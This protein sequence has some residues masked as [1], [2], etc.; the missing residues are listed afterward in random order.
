MN[1]QIL[2]GLNRPNLK[3]DSRTLCDRFTASISPLNRFV[4]GLWGSL[5]CMFSQTRTG[6]TCRLKNSEYVV[7]DTGKSD[8]GLYCVLL[9]PVRFENGTVG[10]A[11]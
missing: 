3:E 1:D 4:R 8:G 9:S 2:I 5:T 10:E 6:R 7:H 11:L